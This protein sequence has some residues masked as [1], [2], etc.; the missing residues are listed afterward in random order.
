MLHWK[1]SRSARKN[2]FELMLSI[3]FHNAA[4]K[5]HLHSLLQ[6]ELI[7]A[8]LK[9]TLHTL[10]PEPS[11]NRCRSRERNKFTLYNTHEASF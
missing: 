9:K 10:S 7:T 2:S 4:S 3:Y 1:V 6:F 5:F 11:V 8:T